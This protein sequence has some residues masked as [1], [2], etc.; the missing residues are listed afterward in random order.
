MSEPTSVRPSISDILNKAGVRPA[1]VIAV[2]PHVSP[3]TIKAIFLGRTPGVTQVEALGE[4]LVRLAKDHI[5]TA[6]KYVQAAER[7]SLHYPPP[8]KPSGEEPSPKDVA[9]HII[10]RAESGDK[11]SDI[12]KEHGITR[13][14]VRQRVKTHEKR[15]GKKIPRYGKG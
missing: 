8:V 4:A 3:H 11:L 15:T 6:D 12:A 9:S 5:G 1:E 14:A 7:L 2:A 13:E 10:Y